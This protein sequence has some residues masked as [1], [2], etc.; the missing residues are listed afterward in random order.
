MPG[1]CQAGRV[2]L[3]NPRILAKSQI[4]T[5]AEVW[6]PRRRTPRR[7]QPNRCRGTH[8]AA[9]YRARAAVCCRDPRRPGGP[10][11]FGDGRIGTWCPARPRLRD[12]RRS[13]VS[14][15]G[16]GLL[17]RPAAAWRA[18]GVRRRPDRHRMGR[19]QIS[20]GPQSHV[21]ETLGPHRWSPPGRG[22]G[23][24]GQ[25]VLG[26]PGLDGSRS[27]LDGAPIP[28][29]RDPWSPPMVAARSG[30]GHPRQRLRTGIGAEVNPVAGGPPD[31][32]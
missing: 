23:T 16:G 21:I 24:L 31:G 12:T 30:A 25:C 1:D 14:G 28:R 20:M 29:H 15:A 9:G 32:K 13:G 19:D 11:V 8:A 3:P 7:A 17:P 26:G 10:V 4:R 27:N 6:P 18:G 2:V 5:S 22:R